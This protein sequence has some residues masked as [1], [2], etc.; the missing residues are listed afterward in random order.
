MHFAS[1]SA[2]AA[3]PDR[4]IG[5]SG[6][7]VQE[8]GAKTDGVQ[9]LPMLP[10]APACLRV[11]EFDFALARLSVFSYPLQPS[12]NLDVLTEGEAVTTLLATMGLS[13]AAIANVRGVAERTVA[14]QLAAAYRKLGGASRS[15]L[16]RALAAAA[17]GLPSPPPRAVR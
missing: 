12:F 4:P 7:C 11:T 10:A 1:S 8:P 16:R 9:L 17:Q 14:N 6:L 2:R 3:E 5:S 15:C 13:N